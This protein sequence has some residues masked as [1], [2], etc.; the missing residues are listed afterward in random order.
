M[1]SMLS[2]NDKAAS[3][4][5]IMILMILLLPICTYCST[6]GRHIAPIGTMKKQ[7]IQQPFGKLV[8]W[9]F[10]GLLVTW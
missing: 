9:G 6:K 3:K 10:E 7:Q 8:V 2:T 1:F 4:A 5:E